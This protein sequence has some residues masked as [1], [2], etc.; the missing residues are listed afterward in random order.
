MQCGE[1]LA[2]EDSGD[3]LN[4]IE[5]MAFCTLCIRLLTDIYIHSNRRADLGFGA[6]N[7]QKKVW[8]SNAEF[9][10]TCWN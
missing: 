10:E 2:V 6:T 9:I 3:F 7:Q 4:E 5:R 8:S 1:D